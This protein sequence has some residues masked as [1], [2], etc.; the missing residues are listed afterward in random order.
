MALPAGGTLWPPI[1]VGDLAAVDWSHVLAGVTAFPALII[2]TVMALLMNA[3]GIELA[4]GTDVDLDRELRSVGLQNLL[5]GAGG[6][7]PGFT[8]L[9]LTLLA[10]RLG[11]ANR[12]VGVLVAVVVAAALFL[13]RFVLGLVPTPLLGSLLVW[14]GGSLIG[15]WLILSPRRVALREYLVILIIF[16]VIVGGSFPLGI[17]AGLLA[18]VVLFVLEYGRLD[19]VRHV[20]RG[21]QYQS[22]AAGSKD[23]RETLRRHGDAILFVSLQGYL[24]F[25][26]AER[27]RLQ[28]LERDRRRF[29]ITGPL[30]GDRFPSC[31]RARIPRR[32]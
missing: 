32:R 6:G 4:T 10:V 30:R 5:S 14:V 16:A 24:F 20:M 26:T 19:T 15:Q 7:L 28:D 8:G 12:M 1:A 27:L 11:A 2:V 23:R 25:G 3:T 17:L 21:S 9:S 29:A 31:Q 18:A 13:G 22:N